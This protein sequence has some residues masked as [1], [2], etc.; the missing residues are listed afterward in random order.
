MKKGAIISLIIAII[1]IILGAI[2]VA[3]AFS[4]GAASHLRDEYHNETAN[5]KD[6]KYEEYKNVDSIS[7][8]IS[9]GDY[10]ISQGEAFSIRYPEY[11]GSDFETFVDADGMWH[12]SGAVYSKKSIFNFIPLFGWHKNNKVYI[13]I[14]ADAE[15]S[16]VNVKLNAG[17]VEWQ[18]LSGNGCIIEINA[19]NFEITDIDLH[20]GLELKC[21]AGNLT[22]NNCHAGNLDVKLDA[23]N[24]ELNG[25]IDGDINV[26]SNMGNVELNL[27]GNLDDYNYKIEGSLGNIELNGKE[28]SGLSKEVTVDNGADKNLVLKG[29]LG[30]IDVEIR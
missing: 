18:G 23:G 13:T 5:V 1:F 30:N 15:F 28:Y 4:M 17:N 16:S 20:K 11:E 24:A 26:K 12:I 25:E 14:P 10:E 22:L 29:N 6:L 19:G 8:E 2:A 21:A 3:T 7:F 27:R 9:A